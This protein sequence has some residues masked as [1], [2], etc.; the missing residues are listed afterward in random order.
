MPHYRINVKQLQVT[1]NNDPGLETTFLY[2]PLEPSA[3]PCTIDGERIIGWSAF[4]SNNSS[5][6]VKDMQS[7]TDWTRESFVDYGQGNTADLLLVTYHNVYFYTNDRLV[8]KS[9]EE[10]ID[11][12]KEVEL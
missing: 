7:V 1:I 6:V 3:P 8:V 5:L 12:V 2:V 11:L 9:M 10:G 4:N